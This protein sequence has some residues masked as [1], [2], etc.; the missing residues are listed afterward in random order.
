[1]KDARFRAGVGLIVTNRRGRVLAIERADRPG[2]WQLPQGGLKHG[3]LP[4]AAA[5]REL[6]EETGLTR[7]D[8]SVVAEFPVWLGYE[9]PRQYHSSK[10]GRGQV[11]RWFVLRLIAAESAIVLPSDGEARAWRWLTFPKLVTQTIPF[12]REVYRQLSTWFSRI[13]GQG[14]S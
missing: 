10:T 11:H 6:R 9:L 1:M 2:A 3:E 14:S 4:K 12:R 7:R 13:P 8:V 5:L